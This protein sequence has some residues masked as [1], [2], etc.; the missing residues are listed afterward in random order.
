METTKLTIVRHG[1]TEWNVAMRLQGKLN[2]SLT[3]VGRKQIEYAAKALRNRKFEMLI[4]SDLGRAMETA[5]IINSYHKLE[6]NLSENLRERNFGVM[7]GL[8]REEVAEKYPEV[9]EGY[10]TR[11][12]NYQVPDGESLVQFY[13]RVSAELKRIVELWPGKNILAISHGGV[14]DCS[15][16]M[17]F[18]ISLDACRNFTIYNASINTFS[19]SNNQWDLEEC[20]NI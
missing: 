4:T 20:V 17:V 18:G 16:R 3:T 7:E 1:E 2:S 19:F 12:S 14:L 10:M 5:M 8:T 11:K 6:V 9:H 15:M 13:A